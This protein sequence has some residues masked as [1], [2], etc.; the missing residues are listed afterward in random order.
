MH[1]LCSKRGTFD[2]SLINLTDIYPINKL[3][4]RRMNC[5]YFLLTCSFEFQRLEGEAYMD[6]ISEAASRST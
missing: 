5:S 3:E 2:I 1:G 6:L 4:I